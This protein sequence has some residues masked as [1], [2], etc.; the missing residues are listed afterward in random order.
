MD[1]D[2]GLSSGYYLFVVDIL[3][4]VNVWV[5]FKDKGAEPY[6]FFWHNR[7]VKIDKINF[8]H[9]TKNGS[10][11]FY[12]FSVSSQGNFYRLGFD[13]SSLKWFLEA[14]EEE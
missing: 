7:Q 9:K 2:F 12:H 13:V 11:Q 14:V 4:P 5:F 10:S 8:I 6:L 1:I 3:E